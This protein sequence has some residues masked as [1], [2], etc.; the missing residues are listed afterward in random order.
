MKLAAQM[1]RVNEQV[2]TVYT[3]RNPHTATY[4]SYPPLIWL[5]YCQSITS[6][7]VK[8]QNNHLCLLFCNGTLHALHTVYANKNLPAFLEA[9][10]NY[11]RK[12]L[13]RRDIFTVNVLRDPCKTRKKTHARL[14]AQPPCTWHDLWAPS[15]LQKTF[16]AMTNTTLQL[17]KLLSESTSGNLLINIQI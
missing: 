3:G 17:K 4:E 7:F 16:T 1:G 11:L 13:H 2:W 15:T 9:A 8:K 14:I 10:W 12:N 6:V 5:C